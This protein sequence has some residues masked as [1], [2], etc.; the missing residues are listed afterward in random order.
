MTFRKRFLSA[1]LCL[2]LLYTVVPPVLLEAASDDGSQANETISGTSITAQKTGDTSFNIHGKNKAEEYQTTYRDVGYQT[3]AS[4]DGGIKQKNPSNLIAAGLRLDVDLKIENDN[5]IKVLYTLTNSGAKSH[6]VKVGSQA[7]VMIDNNDKAPIWAETDGGNTL[8]MSGSPKNNYAFKLVATTCDTLWYGSFHKRYENCFTDMADRG[9]DNIYREDSGL[10]YSWNATVAPGETWTR[11]VL[12]GTGS[13]EEM[14]ITAP[15]IPEPEVIIPDPSIELIADEIYYTEGETLPEQAV[16]RGWRFVKSYK[17]SLTVTGIPTDSNTPGTYTVAYTTTSN[18]K[19]AVATLKVHILPKPAALSKTT[20][21]E[22]GSFSLSATMQYT[23]GLTWTETG[24]V[25][26]VISKP[27]LSQNDGIIQTSKAVSTKGGALSASVAKSNLTEGLQYYARAYAKAS[28]GRV[29]YGESSISFGI[30]VPKYGSFSVKNNGDNTFTISRTGGTSGTQ[31][32]YYRTVNGS[33]VGSTHFTHKYGT[34]TFNAGSSTSQIV[35]VK[36]L[37]VNKAYSPYGVTWEGTPYTNANRTYQLEI[38]RVEGGASVTTAKATR[39]MQATDDYKIDRNIY[40]TERSKVN[41]QKTASG[42]NGERIADATG[43]QGSTTTNVNFGLN[44]YG[45]ANYSTSSRL[46]T[47]YS[48]NV[49]AYLKNTCTDW[50]YRYEMYAYEEV[51]GYEHAYIGTVKLEKDFYNIAS[52]DDAVHYI[53]GQLWACSFLQGQK[54]THN[55]Y[56][57]PAIGSGGGE[58]S[59]KPKKWNGTQS[60]ASPISTNNPG[61]S[62]L[63]YVTPGID[64]TCYLHFSAT[65]KSEDIWWINGLTSYALPHDIREPQ[66][67]GVAPMAGGKYLSGDSVTLSLIFDEIVDST[68]SSLSNSSTITTSWGTFYYAGGADTNVLYFTGT[69]P[70]D[71]DTPIKLTKVDCNSQIK[72]MS[73]DT[74]TESWVTG[75]RSANVSVGKAAAPTVSVATITNSSGTLSST[76]SAENAVKLEYAWSTSSMLPTYGWTTSSSP[77]SVSVKTARSSGTYYLHARATN[78]DGRIVT[79]YKRVTIPSYGTGAAVSPILSVSTSNTTWAKTQE[80]TV[81]RSPSST[82]VTITKPD[83]KTEI[84]NSSGMGFS[85]TATANGVYTFTMIHNGETLT[86]QAV[87]SKIDTTAPTITIDDLPGTSYTEQ[88][89]L[90]FSVADSDSGVNT[91]TAKWGTADATLTNNGDGTYSVTCPN[92][93]GTHTLTVTATDKVGNNSSTTS[94]SYTVNLNAPTLTVNKTSET[95]TGVT[96]AYS[97]SAKGNSNVTVRLP[98]GTETTAL[99]GNFTLTEAGSYIVVVTDAAGH[100]V[101]KEI[102]VTE[103]VDGV[104]PDVRLY[105]DDTTDKASLSVEVGIY[106]AKAL[107]TVTKNGERLSVT[108]AGDGEYTASF[109]VTKGGIY[110][111]TAIDTSGNRGADSVTVYA[112][113]NG[114][115]T[116]LK[117]TEDGKYGELPALH[118]DGY[119]FNGWYTAA[120]GGTKVESGTVV[121]S[122][123]TLY[124]QWTHTDHSGGEATCTTKAVCEVCGAEYGEI[125]PDN[126]DII[127]HNA[128]AATCTEK[129]WNAYDTCSRCNYTTIKEIPAAGHDYENG[130]WLNDET[131]HWKQCANCD[132][133]QTPAD[134]DFGEW[135][136]GKRSCKTC[137]YKELQAITVTISWNEMA[138]TYTDGIWDPETHNYS[139]GEWKADSTDGNLITVE[140]QGDGEV[141]VSFVYAQINDSVGGHFADEDGAAIDSSVSLPAHNK[142]YARLLL[143]GKPDKDM[144]AETVGTVTVYLGG[145][146]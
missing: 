104:A 20:V 36:E 40:I 91:V 115:T 125:T 59:C 128:K 38:Y 143:S 65:G 129:G 24:F 97:V 10:A 52:T 100:F 113:T 101:S 109:T 86:Q 17:G 81:N 12:I 51:D 3:I 9:P 122:T 95:A 124:A 48:G 88:V 118:K 117:I 30:A 41:I 121:G 55:L 94:K 5:Y 71:A 99:T 67:V 18:N 127:H 119:I 73:S 133:T 144:N 35:E 79:Q 85:Y 15:V 83:G 126:H 110:T 22:T 98:S 53:N 46:D 84:Y 134:H 90:N 1:V 60:D 42:A 49:L 58:N 114:S 136:G 76:I 102:E 19:T 21:K 2:C 31:T 141:T 47:Y 57:F 80:I 63:Y 89:T 103:N 92:A 123:Y 120:S 131:R 146:T 111:V 8:I 96:Y 28:D 105:A 82:K 34:L 68:N 87:V 108:G 75:S 14:E 25:Y 26:G 56:K 93:T 43:S 54:D 7:D 78:S 72:D 132:S 33:A 44:R 130:T 116:V 107:S 64:D 11:C 13:S 139:L 69:V 145:N 138:F 135:I 62:G 112:L 23:G 45:Q 140:N 50:L 37:G 29:I 39:T 137:G 106:E 70:E 6:T 74:G 77:S 61:H 66:L 32:V 4:V 142:T 27:T 16:W